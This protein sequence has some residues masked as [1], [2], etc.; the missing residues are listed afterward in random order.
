MSSSTNIEPAVRT[1]AQR[2]VT[3]HRLG[4]AVWIFLGLI[5]SAAIFVPGKEGEDIA[6]IAS[7]VF[8]VAALFFG[9]FYI[10]FMSARTAQLV[11]LL[12]HRRHELRQP[13]LIVRKVNGRI[14]GYGVSVRDTANRKYKM[15]V[16]GEHDARAMLANI[17]P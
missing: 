4:G 15:Q 11:E 12:L 13:V 5:F 2:Q 16:L 10:K 3:I 14:V 6:R 7:A 1:S 8:G 17:P 9:V